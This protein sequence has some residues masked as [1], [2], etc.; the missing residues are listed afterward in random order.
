MATLPNPQDLARELTA[1]LVQHGCR[2]GEGMP[3][4]SARFQ[5]GTNRRT[6]DFT[7]AVEQ[8]AAN[9]WVVLT[10]SGFWITLTQAGFVAA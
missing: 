5:F 10:R 3:I 6:E 8:A 7:A 4:Q 9:G 1:V 2:Q